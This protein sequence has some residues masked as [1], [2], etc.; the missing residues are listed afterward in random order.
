MAR[1][2]AVVTGASSGIGAATARHLV[3]AGFEVVLAARREDRLRAL[4]D[5]LGD[6]ASAVVCDVTD[7]ASVAALAEQVGACDVLVANA[8]L[9]SGLA[10]VAEAE[11]D[12]WRRM[13][14]VDVLGVVAT[15]RALLPA[16]RASGDGHVV[17]VTSTAGHGVYPGGG[18]YTA[19]KHAAV[20]VVETLRLELL[21]EP[22]RVSE[23]A[24]GMVA[25][26]EFSVV[27]FDGDVERADAVYEGVDAL[28]V[29]DVAECVGFVVTRPSHVDVDRLVVQ[30]RQQATPRDLHRGPSRPG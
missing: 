20:A 16:L 9:A 11:L 8:G 25:G 24:P 27:R 4:A 29:D 5:A 15:V 13:Y 17:V 6:A 18:G 14:E 22:V 10:P 19:A 1:R 21:G 28:T 2:R 7:E 3:D 12:R 23:V 30:P 26:A